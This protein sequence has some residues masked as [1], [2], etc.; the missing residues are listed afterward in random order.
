MET[1]KIQQPTVVLQN[2]EVVTPKKRGRPRKS[3]QIV[4]NPTPVMSAWP[5]VV[6]EFPDGKTEKQLGRAERRRRREAAKISYIKPK[7]EAK[8]EVKEVQETKEV[9][10]VKEEVEVV[11]LK[12]ESE[13]DSK[14]DSK[15]KEDED[16]DSE[17]AEEEE[18]PKKQRF[19]PKPPLKKKRRN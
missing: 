5:D 11:V 19:I 15:K 9:K 7:V 8:A 1:P 6:E 4:N 18:P 16:R 3:T 12:D 13:E 10:E 17:T 14:E 2:I